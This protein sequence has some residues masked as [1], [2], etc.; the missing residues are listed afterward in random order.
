MTKMRSISS[1]VFAIAIL[2]TS[3]YGV[4]RPNVVILMSDDLG[5]ADLSCYN[6]PVNTPAID[7]L[8]AKGVRF[9]TFYAGA[10]VCSP[11]RAV[12]LTGR[13]HIRAGVYNWIYDQTQNSH[14]LE[15]EITIAELLKQAGYET[16]HLGKWHLGL[17]MRGRDKPTPV[18]HGFDYWFATANNAEPTHHNPVNFIRNG[19]AVG[20]LEG[21]ACQLVVDEAIHWL[22]NHR[23]ASAPF[24]LNVW[25]HEPHR[26]LAAPAELIAANQGAEHTAGLDGKAQAEAPLYSA[27]IENTDKAIARLLTKLGQVA[28]PENTLII[29]TSDNGSFMKN[30]NGSFRGHKGVNWEGGL[31]V[32]GIFCW[33][34]TIMPGQVEETAA[35]MVDILPTLCSLLQIEAPEVHLDGTDIAALLVEGKGQGVA[36]PQPF[37]WQLYR[38]TPIVAIRDGDYTLVGMRDNENLP[39]TN[40]MNEKWIPLIKNGGYTDYQLFD[41]SKDPNQTTDIASQFPEKVE[42][43]KKKLL[44]INA[45]VMADGPDWHLKGK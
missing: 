18:Q 21:Y 35:G 5:S 42:A 32:P 25:F 11:S 22:D 9:E 13:H 45:S 27:T 26:Y 34:D 38:S 37:Y 15:R 16:A 23:D 2:L 31:R 8:A 20:K 44:A 36:R 19:K 14:L 30:R 29:Y 3:L 1:T 24:F 6:G 39:V 4:Q 28:P 43:L 7:G 40:R 33:P 41:L 10:S 12:L 17:P